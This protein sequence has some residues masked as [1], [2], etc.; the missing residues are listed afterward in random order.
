MT[1]QRLMPR[2][3][4]HEYVRNLETQAK[5][6]AEALKDAIGAIND[7]LSACGDAEIREHPVLNRHAMIAKRAEKALAAWEGVK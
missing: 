3:V 2:S 1:E 7:E 5:R 4:T 6:L